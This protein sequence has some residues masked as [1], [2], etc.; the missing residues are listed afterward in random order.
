MAD[1]RTPD[2]ALLDYSN[3]VLD[4]ISLISLIG[5][6]LA[7]LVIAV[8]LL[9]IAR[10]T[11]K[12]PE[13]LLGLSF[14]FMLIGN[15]VIVWASETDTMTELVRGRAIEGGEVAL[16]IGFVFVAAF[17]VH[18]FRQGSPR[19]KALAWLLCVALLAAQALSWAMVAEWGRFTA[20]YFIKFGIRGCIYLRLSTS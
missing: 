3:A 2:R 18:V 1:H 7:T 17:N 5:F 19:A 8:H 16:D 14:L 9:A 12:A 6:S 4:A 20:L 15:C 10:R 11:R 13:L